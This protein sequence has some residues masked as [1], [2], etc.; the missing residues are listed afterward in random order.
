MITPDTLYKLNQVQIATIWKI[1]RDEFGNVQEIW[2]KVGGIPYQLDP[3]NI[4]HV[5]FITVNRE[6]VGIG[7]L[8]QMLQPSMNMQGQIIPPLYVLKA[9]LTYDLIRMVHRKGAPH[10]IFQFLDAGDEELQKYEQAIMNPDVD[11]SWVTNLQASVATEVAGPS[12]GLKQVLDYLNARWQAALQTPINMLVTSSGYTEASARVAKE[13]GGL[14]IEKIQLR[15]KDFVE[16]ELYDRILTQNGFDP[17]RA[18]IELHY[19]LPEKPV[20]TLTEIGTLFDRNLIMPK[21]AREFLRQLGLELRDDTEFMEFLKNRGTAFAARGQSVAVNPQG[22]DPN[23]SIIDPLNVPQQ[24]KAQMMEPGQVAPV[25]LSA[26]A[27]QQA[28]K[29]GEPTAQ[30]KAPAQAT[31]QSKGVSESTLEAE[32]LRIFSALDWN[33]RPKTN[34]VPVRFEQE[35]VVGKDRWTAGHQQKRGAK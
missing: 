4:I 17:A 21:E 33:G 20:F 16:H 12:A 7:V 15:L 23:P 13:L 8:E 31:A 32:S 10:T 11:A 27:Q 22:G 6:P 35:H 25:N 5:P 34:K 24:A 26:L 30:V 3:K 14:L 2:Q 19:G 9:S 28:Q 1:N 29:S 18:R